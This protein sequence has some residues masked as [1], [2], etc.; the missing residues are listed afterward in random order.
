M[1]HVVDMYGCALDRGAA[2]MSLAQPDPPF[3]QSRRPIRA[4]A[5]GGVEKVR[6]LDR[7]H[8]L[9]CEI[10]YERDLPLG[11]WSHLLPVDHEDAEQRIIL[12]KRHSQA[13]PAPT[14]IDGCAPQRIADAI[15][16]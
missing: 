5:K 11:K 12:E 6:I 13:G 2:K 16:F 9:R 14:E 1:L 3:A 10:L 4:H 7:D 8:R 15:S